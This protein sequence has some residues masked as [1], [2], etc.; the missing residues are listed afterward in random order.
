MQKNSITT[1]PL[2]FVVVEGL[3][4]EMNSSFPVKLYSCVLAPLFASVA[5][6]AVGSARGF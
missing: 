1:F 5:V 6:V 4:L 3:L 2:V